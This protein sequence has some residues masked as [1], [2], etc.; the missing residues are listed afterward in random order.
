MWTC[1]KCIA[2]LLDELEFCPY[3]GTG[4]DGSQQIITSNLHEL[5]I[6]TSSELEVRLAETG[7]ETQWANCA[8]YEYFVVPFVGRL[9]QGF[10]SSETARS[11]SRQLQS[12]INQYAERGWEF[13][14]VEKVDI[15]VTPGWLASLLGA[16]TSHISFDQIVFR[17]SIA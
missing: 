15:E 9:K 16:K 2:Q 14:S 1:P 5:D 10:F 6:N 13:C 4:K 8:K 3:C 7:A 11:V 17:R 12:E